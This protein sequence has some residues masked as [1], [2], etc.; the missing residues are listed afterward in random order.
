MRP[1]THVIIFVESGQ[2]TADHA[3]PGDTGA[4]KREVA[5]NDHLSFVLRQINKF[6]ELTLWHFKG[7]SIITNTN[8]VSCDMIDVLSEE[9]NTTITQGTLSTTWVVTA[10][11]M[12]TTVTR[13]LQPRPVLV[14]DGIP[15]R[16]DRPNRRNP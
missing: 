5:V 14:V 13:A 8:L 2:E 6:V 11:A 15:H 9:T 12:A 3:R 10:P 1:K 16:V 4:K 7:H